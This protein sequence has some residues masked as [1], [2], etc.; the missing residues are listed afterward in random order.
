MAFERVSRWG[1]GICLP[2][3][4]CLRQLEGFEYEVRVN[5]HLFFFLF[6]LY[7]HTLPCLEPLS[8]SARLIAPETIPSP[9]ALM[10]H[11]L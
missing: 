2:G 6:P 3:A 11:S 5:A 7:T 8:P 9:A 1:W 4:L 10:P